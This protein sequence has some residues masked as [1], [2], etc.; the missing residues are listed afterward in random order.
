MSKVSDKSY[1]FGPDYI[2]RFVYFEI[3]QHKYTIWILLNESKSISRARL[4]LE[5]GQDMVVLCDHEWHASEPGWHCHFTREDQG[6]VEP[7]AVRTGKKRWPRGVNT[8]E[9][10]VTKANVI[11]KTLEFFGAGMKG[12]LL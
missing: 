4:G 3:Q 8:S 5:V 7:G 12:E 1:K 9:F 11:D 10:G 2:H 6:K